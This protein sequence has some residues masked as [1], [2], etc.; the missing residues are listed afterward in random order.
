LRFQKSLFLFFL[1]CNGASPTEL[2]EGVNRTKIGTPMAPVAKLLDRKILDVATGSIDFVVTWAIPRILPATVSSNKTS[3]TYAV[4]RYP[5][6]NA[7][8]LP[9]TLIIRPSARL[10]YL[11]RR[12]AIITSVLS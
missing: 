8:Q 3:G 5:R 12:A 11:R 2:V 7:V 10:D 6:T 1:E 9:I 4:W